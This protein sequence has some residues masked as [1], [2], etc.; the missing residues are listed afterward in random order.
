[1]PCR[2]AFKPASSFLC[3]LSVVTHIHSSHFVRDPTWDLGFWPRARGQKVSHTACR[4]R[5][6]HGRQ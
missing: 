2:R 5:G 1:M 3:L 4:S 6:A